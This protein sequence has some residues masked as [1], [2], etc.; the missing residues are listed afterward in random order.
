MTDKIYR[1]I[2]DVLGRE[3]RTNARQSKLLK[4]ENFLKLLD[5]I[6]ENMDKIEAQGW[7][8]FYEEAGDW[9]D[10]SAASIDKNLDIL[11]PHTPE[12]IRRW[13]KGGLGFDHIEKANAWQGFCQMDAAQ[14]LDGALDFGNGNGKRMTVLEMKAFALGERTPLPPTYNFVNTLSKWMVSMPR[15][16]GWGKEK[17]E[18][19][20][21]DLK[22]LIRKYQ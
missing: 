1:L 22:E 10:Y 16:L 9:M 2:P 6:E 7:E 5:F 21:A 3:L 17:A 20:V 4:M 18:A 14:I 11:R 12:N 8:N 13:L 19:F 15:R